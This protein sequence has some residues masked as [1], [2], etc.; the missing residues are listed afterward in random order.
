MR[1]GVGNT[2]TASRVNSLRQRLRLVDYD[3]TR[4]TPRLTLNQ[5]AN[6]LGVGLWVVRGLIRCGL[7]EATQV[8][9]CAPWQIAAIALALVGLL[10]AMRWDMTGAL[11]VASWGVAGTLALAM[12]G[13]NIRRVS[14]P[15]IWRTGPIEDPATWRAEARLF[16][17]YRIALALLSQT[18]VIAL[19]WLQPSAAAVGAYAAAMGTASLA[20]VLATATN[21]AYARRLA[22]LLERR[23]SRP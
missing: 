6:R 22:I 14:P 1:T 11:A 2:W 16:W 15:E 3:E 19:D 9:P 4:A 5:A 17:I 10:I 8:M 18:G 7:L 12:L 20:L 21:R 13:L 23:R